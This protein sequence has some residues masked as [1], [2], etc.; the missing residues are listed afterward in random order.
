MYQQTFGLNDYDYG[1]T[2]AVLIVVLGIV[3]SK[4]VGFLTQDPDEKAEKKLARQ[5]KKAEKKGV[6]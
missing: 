6:A 2:L 5:R 3:V 4:G 1:S